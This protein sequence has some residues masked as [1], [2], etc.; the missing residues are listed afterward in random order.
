MPIKTYYL[1]FTATIPHY[2]LIHEEYGRHHFGT[3]SPQL[4]TGL[5]SNRKQNQ[6]TAAAVG[7]WGVLTLYLKKTTKL[8][9]FAT[10]KNPQP[11]QACDTRAYIFRILFEFLCLSHSQ[12]QWLSLGLMIFV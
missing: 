6:H 2:L 11:L 3:D 12:C 4:Y 7:G 5:V 1:K 9:P 10:A 8:M